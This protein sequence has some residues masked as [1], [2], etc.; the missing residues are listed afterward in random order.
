MKE[1]EPSDP[2]VAVPTALPFGDSSSV[3]V[4]DTVVPAGN[5]AEDVSLPVRVRAVPRVPVTGALAVSVVAVLVG[6]SKTRSE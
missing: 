1:Y 4:T 5:G 6:S 2:T 3:R